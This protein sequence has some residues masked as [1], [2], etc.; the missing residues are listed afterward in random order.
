M[1]IMSWL[2]HNSGNSIPFKLEYLQ[3]CWPNHRSKATPLFTLNF[4]TDQGMF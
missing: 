1:K 4:Y 3:V 2:Y